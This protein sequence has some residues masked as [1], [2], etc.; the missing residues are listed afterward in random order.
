[1]MHADTL[2]SINLFIVSQTVRLLQMLFSWI[3]HFPPSQ[4]LQLNCCQK[5]RMNAAENEVKTDK[6]LKWGKKNKL[7]YLKIRCDCGASRRSGLSSFIQPTLISESRTS[8]HQQV[9]SLWFLCLFTCTRG[10]PIVG[11][12][13]VHVDAVAALELGPCAICTFCLYIYIHLYKY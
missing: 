2:Y 8:R 12:C 4:L 6:Q 5:K 13:N 9:W 10:K 7:V 11:R 1:M 3:I